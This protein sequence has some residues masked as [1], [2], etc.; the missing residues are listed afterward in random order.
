M[1]Q[2]YTGV[3]GSGKSY[4][5]VHDLSR[6]LEKEPELTVMANINGLKLEH[7]DFDNFIQERFPE[8]SLS[9]TERLERFFT[10]EYQQALNDEFGGPVMYVLDECQMY[11]PK[12]TKLPKTEAYLQRHRHLGHY[13]YLATQASSYIS[14]T[15]VA[16]V[17]LEYRSAPRSASLLGELRYHQKTPLSNV[18]IS[19]ITHRPKKKIFDLYKSFE[20]EEIRKPKRLLLRKLWPVLL[21]PFA[22]LLFWYGLPKPPK[23]VEAGTP[24]PVVETKTPMPTTDLLTPQEIAAQSEINRLKQQIEQLQGE[25]NK[26]VRVFLSIVKTADRTLT[27]DPETNAVV[28]LKALRSR[29]VTCV[30]DSCFYDKPVKS[31][32]EAYEAK[33][34]AS[35]GQTRTWTSYAPSVIK[36]APSAGSASFVDPSIVLEPDRYFPQRAFGE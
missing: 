13:I 1:I 6:L 24:P 36:E 18:I 23:K 8:P 5:L 20:N 29:G 16:L 33:S 32:P 12:G 4:K 15:I 27:V 28:E 14:R 10:Y 3:P 2:L 25:D 19:T 31:M 17:E 9:M 22:V 21:L 26:M 7:I 34:P 35:S 30:N 11:F